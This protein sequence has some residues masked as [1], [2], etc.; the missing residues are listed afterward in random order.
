V[1]LTNIIYNLLDNANKYSPEKP[2]ITIHTENAVGGGVKIVVSD[3]GIGMSRDNIKKIFDKFY[4]VSTGDVHDVK[5]FGLGLSYVKRIVEAHGG[6][7]HV[8]SEIGK[9][10]Q[11]TLYFPP[12]TIAM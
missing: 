11:F 8:K 5:G 10:S 1:H 9:G 3:R 2:R 4:R 7:I 6:T 12:E